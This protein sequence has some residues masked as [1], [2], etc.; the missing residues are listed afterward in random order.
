MSGPRPR[1]SRAY[2][3]SPTSA[4]ARRRP[5]FGQRSDIERQIARLGACRVI[6]N[7]LIIADGLAAGHLNSTSN[8]QV[9][10]T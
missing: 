3:V 5:F 1:L 6:G 8:L 4:D 9:Y 2:G 10:E 7:E